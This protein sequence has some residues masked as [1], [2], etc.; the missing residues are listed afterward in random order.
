MPRPAP[1]AP[2]LA[3]TYPAGTDGQAVLRRVVAIA[4]D[5][6]LA[7][8]GLLQH[9]IQRPDR[10]KCDMEVEDLHSGRR[11]PITADRGAGARGCHLDPGL[12]AEAVSAATGAVGLAPDLMVVS[13]FGKV[14]AEGGGA[15]QMIADAVEAGIP[16]LLA[17]PQVNL[18][19]WRRFAGDLT[20]EVE[21]GGSVDDTAAAL[22]GALGM[23]SRDPVAAP[24]ASASA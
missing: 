6:G 21:A 19:P 15:R 23:A 18:D 24:A 11:Y 14:E 8:G 22:L 3:L 17:V 9:D 2:I 7:V 1:Q 4:R 20:L 13:K 5:A 16:V 10:R 12:L